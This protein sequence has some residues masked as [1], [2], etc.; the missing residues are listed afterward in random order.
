M[1]VKAPAEKNFRRAKGKPG[2]RKARR[3]WFSWRLVRVTF[4]AAVVIYGV[5]RA[6]ALV[7]DATVLQV[8]RISVSGNVRLSRGEVQQLVH[9]LYGANILTVDLARYRRAILDSPWVAEAALR[10][11]LPS[12]VE[13]SVVERQP[14]GIS[15]LRHQLYLVDREGTVIDEFGPK[16]SD[17]DLPIVDGLV[18]APRDG[19]P[20]IDP[21][22]AHL[23]ASVVD[24]LAGDPPLAR[25]LSQIDVS[26]VHNAAVLLDDDPA[27]LYL[28]EEK[29]RERLKSYLEVADAIRAGV[30]SEIDY[31]DLR[32]GQRVFAGQRK[33]TTGTGGKPSKGGRSY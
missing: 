29:F 30:P 16:Y 6:C 19:K 10:R 4:A 22:R 32:F 12:T 3:A 17:F 25:R 31:V 14:F 23:A 7:L 24:S 21:A 27:L 15:R 13:I 2:R 8:D 9:G 1:K 26:D 33:G 28:G 11:V 18:T 20:A 5:Y